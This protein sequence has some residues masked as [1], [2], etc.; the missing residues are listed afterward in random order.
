[1]QNCLIRKLPLDQRETFQ[2]PWR[3]PSLWKGCSRAEL[4]IS[5]LNPSVR[6]TVPACLL[7]AENKPWPQ[8]VQK[9]RDG[10]ENELQTL[11]RGAMMRC[12]VSLPPPQPPPQ[13]AADFWHFPPMPWTPAGA[14]GKG[15]SQ[16]ASSELT[17][18]NSIGQPQSHWGCCLLPSLVQRGLYSPLKKYIVRR[19]L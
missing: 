1:M 8:K 10:A 4:N 3:S 18:P 17:D 13:A 19:I 12:K 16:A 11:Q 7:I 14:N 5:L 9:L 15:Q 6:D 2:L